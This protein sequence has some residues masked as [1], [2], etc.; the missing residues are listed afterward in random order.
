[1]S[2]AQS[3]RL[4][5]LLRRAASLPGA[6]PSSRPFTNLAKAVLN[7]IRI[8]L[9]HD[10]FIPILPKRFEYNPVCNDIDHTKYDVN[11]HYLHFSVVD[12]GPRGGSAFLKRQAASGVRLLNNLG[13]LHGAVADNTLAPLVLEALLQRYLLAAI[14]CSPPSNFF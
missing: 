1:M 6:S 13:T 11:M 12:S 8:A 2:G 9:Q 3:R 10:V 7:R 4:A 14:R 5:S